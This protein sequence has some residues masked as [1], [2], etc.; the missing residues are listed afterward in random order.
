M[1][2]TKEARNKK[3]KGIKQFQEY[4]HVSKEASKENKA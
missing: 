2:K 4:L 1:S 3:H